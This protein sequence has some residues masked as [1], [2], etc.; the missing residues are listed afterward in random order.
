[1]DRKYIEEHGVVD[2]YVEGKLSADETEAFEIVFLEDRELFEQVRLAQLL[3]DGLT[4]ATGPPVSAVEKPE[5]GGLGR[6]LLSPGAAVVA[7]TML[8]VAVVVATLQN[9]ELVE[10]RQQAITLEDQAASANAP[11]A[12]VLIV[13]LDRVR[14]A[15]LEDEPAISIRP[16]PDIRRIVFLPQASGASYARLWYELSRRD[17][18]QVWAGES[19]V[20]GQAALVVPSQSLTAGDYL[21]RIEGIGAD[22]TREHLGEFSFR[23][24]P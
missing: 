8:V 13:P 4:Q 9:R 23:A 10:L 12:G 24:L 21:L 18:Q 11:Q 20:T 3:H 16:T 17:G 14:G 7:I 1:M 6:L 19:R 15:D 22:G 2:L 5:R